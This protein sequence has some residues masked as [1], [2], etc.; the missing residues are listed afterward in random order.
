VG[1]GL[2][3]DRVVGKR[4]PSSELRCTFPFSGQSL[5]SITIKDVAKLAGVGTTTVSRVANGAS[6][7]SAETRTKVLTAI[8]RL[9]YCPNSH[10]IELRHANGGD[11]PQSRVRLGAL[12]GKRAKPPSHPGSDSQNANQQR[13]R[14][15]FLEGEYKRVGR[16]IAELSKDLENLSNDLEKLRGSIQLRE[17]VLI[18]GEDR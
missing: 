15:R 18:H 13:R 8:S 6:N 3:S 11:Y 4:A 5:M 7:V 2:M 1:V 12:V 10:A 9:Q 17:Q 14:L 16:A